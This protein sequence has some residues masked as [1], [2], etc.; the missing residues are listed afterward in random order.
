[1]AGYM[2]DGVET[3]VKLAG[4]MIG[5]IGICATYQANFPASAEAAAN[6]WDF[7]MALVYPASFPALGRGP[8]LALMQKKKQKKIKASAEAGEVGRAPDYTSWAPNTV[9]FRWGSRAF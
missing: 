1:M 9:L 8:F 5:E 6:F 3:L 7:L 2:I 4:Y